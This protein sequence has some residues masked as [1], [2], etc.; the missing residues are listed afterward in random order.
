[1]PGVR[2]RRMVDGSAQGSMATQHTAHVLT[3]CVKGDR[4]WG[5][6]TGRACHCHHDCPYLWGCRM[7]PPHTEDTHHIGPRTTQSSSLFIVETS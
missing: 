6:S 7:S 5:Q 1:M 3:K 4:G 2:S